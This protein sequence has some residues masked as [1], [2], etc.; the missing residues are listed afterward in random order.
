MLAEA[1]WAGA[2]EAA[3]N[4]HGARRRSRPAT[5]RAQR[6]ELDE[7]A[8]DDRHDRLVRPVGRSRPGRP[9]DSPGDHARPVAVAYAGEPGA[10]AE[11]A[12]LAAFGDVRARCRSRLPRGL[13]GGRGG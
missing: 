12:V 8:G 13:R 10:F 3:G 4:R 5:A 2:A 1:H 11:D 7:D 9:L 6:A